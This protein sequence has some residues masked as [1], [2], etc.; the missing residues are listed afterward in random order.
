[1]VISFHYIMSQFKVS[2]D[3]PPRFSS[4]GFQACWSDSC[5]TSP[6]ARLRHSHCFRLDQNISEAQLAV[7]AIRIPL[8][9]IFH[10]SS[11]TEFLKLTGS[12]K[13]CQE[14]IYISSGKKFTGKASF[15]KLHTKPQECSVEAMKCSRIAHSHMSLWFS[16]EWWPK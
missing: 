4:W 7:K 15:C 14:R 3:L 11:S 5:P 12:A 10:S 1:M 16:L 9:G 6:S 13:A 2:S 8:C